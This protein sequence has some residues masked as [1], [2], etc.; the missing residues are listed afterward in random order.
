MNDMFTIGDKVRLRDP[1]KIYNG[2]IYKQEFRNWVRKYETFTLVVQKRIISQDDKDMYYLMP[3]F[4]DAE[5]GIDI[6]PDCFYANE[7]MFKE[8]RTQQWDQ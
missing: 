5:Q 1:S 4:K 7:L 6:S 8:N 2:S 3:R